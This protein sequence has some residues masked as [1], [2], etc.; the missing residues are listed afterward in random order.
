MTLVCRLQSRRR[1]RPPAARRNQLA[2]RFLASRRSPFF[3]QDT[4][5]ITSRVSIS[6][7]GK[8]KARRRMWIQASRRTDWFLSLC[9]IWPAGW[10]LSCCSTL[11]MTFNQVESI[12]KGESIH[13]GKIFSVLSSPLVQIF[14]I[15][16]GYWHFFFKLFLIPEFSL[17]MMRWWTL[18]I[19]IISAL[20][21]VES[22]HILLLHSTWCP[23]GLSPGFTSHVSGSAW[24][25]Q[26]RAGTK[27]KKRGSGQ[28]QNEW[29]SA[30]V[31]II[32]VVY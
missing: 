29:A 26:K 2:L 3:I 9:N 17:K 8:E 7:C 16:T 15:E 30:S 24:Q 5:S 12:K 20:N 10:R 6:S 4:K 11:I 18:F 25:N 23:P 1:L 27:H 13:Q 22:L 31:S 21:P 14:T 32:I 19:S 28:H